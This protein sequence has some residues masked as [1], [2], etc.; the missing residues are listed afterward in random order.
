MHTIH[1]PYYDYYIHIQIID[2]LI[3]SVIGNLTSDLNH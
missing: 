2:E 1:S 3:R